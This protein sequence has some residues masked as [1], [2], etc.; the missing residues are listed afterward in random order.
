MALPAHP[1]R[2]GA[3]PPYRGRASHVMLVGHRSFAPCCIATMFLGAFSVKR[4]N[5]GLCF[6]RH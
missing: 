1:G 4:N 6:T 5:N 2:L 3:G